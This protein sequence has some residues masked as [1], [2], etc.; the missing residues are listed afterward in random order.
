MVEQKKFRFDLFYRLA[1]VHV[2][3]APLRERLEGAVLGEA[4]LSTRIFRANWL[5]ALLDA[6]LSKRENHGHALWALFMLENWARAHAGE[7]I[8]LV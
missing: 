2:R 5:R 6:H 4:A 8:S 1:V 7:P 3:L